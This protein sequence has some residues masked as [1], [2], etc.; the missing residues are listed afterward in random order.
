MKRNF[1]IV[2]YTVRDLKKVSIFETNSKPFLGFV[3]N[4]Y[5]TF[6]KDS[7]IAENHFESDL[8]SYKIFLRVSI[9][10][11]KWFGT[12]PFSSVVTS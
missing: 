10:E 1:K 7:S 5:E 11:T 6:K 12:T 3:G 4:L 8:D 2:S 9:F